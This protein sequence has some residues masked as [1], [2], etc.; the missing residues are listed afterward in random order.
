MTLLTFLTYGQTNND[1]IQVIAKLIAP[2]QGDKIHIAKYKV[3]KVVKGKLTNDTLI[4]MSP[5]QHCLN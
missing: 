5:I 1:T 4:K 3:I 2:G